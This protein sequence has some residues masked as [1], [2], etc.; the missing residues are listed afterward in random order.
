[1]L[2]SMRRFTASLAFAVLSL[3]IVAES[4]KP[5]F[6]QTDAPAPPVKPRVVKE[7]ASPVVV[8]RDGK[9][10]ALGAALAND[11]RILTS[12]SALLGKE[13]ADIKVGEA[14][15]I[16]AKVT[17][18]DPALD[19]A[20]LTPAKKSEDGFR[21]SE[22]DPKRQRLDVFV[23]RAKLERTGLALYGDNEVRKPTGER[24]PAT[25]DVALIPSAPPVGYTDPK[26]P[27]LPP[28][29][30]LLGAPI[31]D[32]AGDLIGLVVRL[33]KTAG[34]SPCAPAFVALGV[35]PIRSFMMSLPPPPAAWLGLAGEGDLVGGTRGVRI[36]AVAPGSPAQRA[37]LKP[38][39][40]PKKAPMV[41]SVDGTPVDSPEALSKLLSAHTA[42]DIV[43][44]SVR[45][46]DR[47][48]EI[49]VTLGSAPETTK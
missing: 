43:K 44:L 14:P 24:I 11:G 4:P 33:C 47:I 28:P 6:A 23:Q 39:A 26:T 8:L 9:V 22:L 48:R 21:A 5:A 36:V 45:E 19:L 1:M 42:G 12:L 10:L 37:G 35:P 32:P 31:V 30:L 40:D 29:A 41:L 17:Q 13:T 27:A 2:E 20:L 49:P 15:A 16:T 3:P 18:K 38:N 25:F 34:A 7:P 46:G